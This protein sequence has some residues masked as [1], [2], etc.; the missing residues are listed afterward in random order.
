MLSR[1]TKQQQHYAADGYTLSHT[2]KSQKAAYSQYRRSAY[3]AERCRANNAGRQLVQ[4][5]SFLADCASVRKEL[6]DRVTGSLRGHSAAPTSA[7]L[8]RDGLRV[9]GV[10]RRRGGR[11]AAHAPS[12]GK[13]TVG[14]FRSGRWRLLPVLLCSLAWRAPSPRCLL[15]VSASSSSMPRYACCWAYPR[16]SCRGVD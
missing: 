4:A 16:A 10:S 14:I 12:C 2:D 13:C 9:W 1:T 15:P 5:E 11:G 7:V 8:L 6:Q 3:L